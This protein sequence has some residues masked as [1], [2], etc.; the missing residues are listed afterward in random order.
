M[1][2]L[3]DFIVSK[4]RIKLLEVFLGSPA[5]MFY[6]RELTRKI[7]EEINAVRR[8]LIHM[9]D[10]GM[11]KEET[12]GNRRYYTFNKNYL[13]H[14]ELM[15]MIGKTT[16]LGKAISH[17]APKLGHIKFAMIS[18]RFVRHMPRA[19]DT[20]DLLLIGE[21]ILP[22]LSELIREQEAV[23]GREINYTVMTN[24]ELEYRKTHNDPFIGRILEGSRVMIIGDE[25]DLVA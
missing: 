17:S 14:K 25:E 13:F 23:L 16:G 5:D 20:V 6:I 22:Q 21:I 10:C 7:D 19:K 4:V 8:E 3:T 9:N 24:E 11:V 1:A 2:N 12:R 18:G 15:S